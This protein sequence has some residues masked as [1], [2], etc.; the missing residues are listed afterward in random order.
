MSP[1]HSE[2]APPGARTG[3]TGTRDGGGGKDSRARGGVV[4]HG[5]YGMGVAGVSGGVG[6]MAAAGVMDGRGEGSL[7]ILHHSLSLTRHGKGAARVMPGGA[8]TAS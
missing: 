1:S 2:G 5:A 3:G 6:A 8:S 7:N 4:G